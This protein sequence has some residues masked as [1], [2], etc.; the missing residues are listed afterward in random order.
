MLYD[1]ASFRAQIP[2]YADATAYPSVTVEGYFE[3]A[4]CYIVE[5]CAL[6]G[7]CLRLALNL[8]T[9]HLMTIDQPAG[10][11]GVG[12]VQSASIDKVS[13]SYAVQFTSSDWRNWLNQSQYGQRL[14]ALLKMKGAP[15][16]IGGSAERQAIRKAGGVF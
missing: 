16:L 6:T 3:Q 1:D 13:V 10:G 12:L 7:A 9:A 4:G 11:S 14:L 2:A 5:S 8:M 15:M